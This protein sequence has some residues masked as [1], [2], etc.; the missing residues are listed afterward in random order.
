MTKVF[1]TLADIYVFKVGTKIL[2]DTMD[3]VNCKKKKKGNKYG[4]RL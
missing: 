4:I 1:N 3:D 2:K